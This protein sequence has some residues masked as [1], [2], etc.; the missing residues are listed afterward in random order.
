MVP[1][2][3]LVCLPMAYVLPQDDP[4][5]NSFVSQWL[6]LKKKDGTIDDLYDHWILGSGVTSTEPRWSILRNVLHWID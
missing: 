2:S 3:Q 5:W 1:K 6:E 4:H